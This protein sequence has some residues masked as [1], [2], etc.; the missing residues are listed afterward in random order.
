MIFENLSSIQ[1]NNF[2]T[3]FDFT[4]NIICSEAELT[5]KHFEY[6]FTSKESSKSRT[7]VNH[8]IYQSSGTQL[9]LPFFIFPVKQ[10]KPKTRTENAEHIVCR[11]Y[12]VIEWML[13]L[14]MLSM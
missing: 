12:Y 2:S 10:D 5:D 1:K 9:F 6:T 4:I 3:L 7:C 8:V 11:M 14:M 13:M